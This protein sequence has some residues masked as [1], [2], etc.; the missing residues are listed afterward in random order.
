[1]DGLETPFVPLPPAAGVPV[2]QKPF[3][4]DALGRK[5]R[6]VLDIEPPFP[7]QPLTNDNR[8]HGQ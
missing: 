7:G 1:M 6:A 5:E 8:A 4:P 2:L 3:S